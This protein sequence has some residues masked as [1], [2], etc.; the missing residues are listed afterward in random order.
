MYSRRR[1][2]SMPGIMEMRSDCSTNSTSD[3][4]MSPRP[5]TSV[6]SRLSA[7]MGE[8]GPAEKALQKSRELDPDLWEARFNL[9]EVPFRQKLA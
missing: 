2:S 5:R 6:A 9:A 7:R 1:T 4:Q 3:S 8:F